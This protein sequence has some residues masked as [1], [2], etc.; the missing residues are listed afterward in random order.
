MDLHRG[1]LNFSG[2]N[3]GYNV[4]Q[5]SPRLEGIHYCSEPC[6]CFCDLC[7][8]DFFAGFV[9]EF[10]EVREDEGLLQVCVNATMS[11]EDVEL[12][13]NYETFTAEGIV[14]MLQWNIIMNNLRIGTVLF[15][16]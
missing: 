4:F 10:F 11:E 6:T 1:N 7:F 16:S 14:I 3:N 15:S 8:T 2:R 9:E 12:A 13:L 5:R